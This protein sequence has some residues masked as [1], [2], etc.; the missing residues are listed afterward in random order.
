M[1]LSCIIKIMNIYITPSVSLCPSL[2]NSFLPPLPSHTQA[3]TYL[4][5]VTID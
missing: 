1:K 2:W 5:S 3:T 4:L